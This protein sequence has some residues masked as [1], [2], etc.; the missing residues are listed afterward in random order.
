MKLRILKY[1]VIYF[2]FLLFCSCAK[3]GSPTGGPADK[4]PPK[5]LKSIPENGAI[6]FKGD[7]I[8]LTFDEYIQLN[9]INENLIISPPL[10][11]DIKTTIRHKT[12]IINLNNKLEDS[13]T[14][15]LNFGSSIVDFR[16][17][18]PIENF[19]FVFSTGSKIDSFSITGKVLKAF[20]LEPPDK[21]TYVLIYN[22]LNDTAPLKVRPLYVGRCDKNGDFKINYLK[23]GKYRIYALTDKNN[24]LKYDLKD[25]YFAFVDTIV[26]INDKIFKNNKI[27]LIDSTI[28]DSAKVDSLMKQQN[29]ESIYTTSINLKLF[30][31]EERN[32][33]ILSKNR[34]DSIKI[35]VNFNRSLFDDNFNF[36]LLDLKPSSDK[37]YL[38]EI[39]KQ[40]DTVTIWLID[41]TL[42]AHDT[43]MTIVKYSI[44][45]T[46]DNYIE[47]IDTIN[48][49]YYGRKELKNK[50]IEKNFKI[51]LNTSL[52]GQGIKELD[53]DLYIISPFPIKRIDKELFTL[54][55]FQDTIY[56]EI[57]IIADIDTLNKR[58]IRIKADLKPG[59]KYKL[60]AKE[61]AIKS[62]YNHYNDTLNI[63][64][65]CRK[66]DYYGKL[67][68]NFDRNYKDVIIQLLNMKGKIVKEEKLGDRKKLIFNYLQPGQYK[69]KA[70]FDKNNNNKWDTGNYRKKIQPEEVIFY[71]GSIDIRSNWEIEINWQI[72]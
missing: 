71:Q 37:W 8:Y 49:I 1:F 32:Q 23:D 11:N 72:F 35:V 54:Q 4:I 25:E 30:K 36:N 69:L 13:V 62:F 53:E 56:K 55:K 26:E 21:N 58:I 60:I 6:N 15:C 18:N 70:Y 44:L 29:F 48:F 66:E 10:K 14:Y 43:L 27:Y 42:F 3:I 63:L 19:E 64:F 41:S 52:Q 33:Y 46:S 51:K 47:K 57:P 7:K 34:P 16:E 2:L 67:I 50:Q 38:K 31:E 65:E 22:N 39:N 5:I 40:K 68:L 45:D 28:I 20:D 12:L 24:N 9:K 59:E 61:E 17:A